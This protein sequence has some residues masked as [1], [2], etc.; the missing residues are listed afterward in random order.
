LFRRKLIER[1]IASEVIIITTWTILL[2]NLTLKCFLNVIAY[3]TAMILI[4]NSASSDVL[5][6]VNGIAQTLASLTRALGPALVISAAT[7]IGWIQSFKIPSEL[8]F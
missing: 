8:G 3:T 1:D 5:G 7:F 2:A 4:N 6:T